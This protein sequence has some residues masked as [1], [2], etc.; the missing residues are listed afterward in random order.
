MLKSFTNWLITSGAIVIAVILI[1]AVIGALWI[2]GL[3]LNEAFLNHFGTKYR[4]GSETEV[5]SPIG[6]K[7]HQG[8]SAVTTDGP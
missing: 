5:S 3:L 1:T 7:P 8:A 4:M 6:M 2:F